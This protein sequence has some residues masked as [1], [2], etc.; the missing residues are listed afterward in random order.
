MQ[1]T[2][3]QINEIINSEELSSLDSFLVKIEWFWWDSYTT[4][5]MSMKESISVLNHYVELLKSYLPKKQELFEQIINYDIR[6]SILNA[7][8][9][10][11]NYIPKIKNWTDYKN[12]F[13]QDVQILQWIFERYM[14]EEKNDWY[15]NY[16]KKQE[17]ITYLIRRY[18]SLQG[19]LDNFEQ[20]YNEVSGSISEINNS[21]SDSKNK[22]EEINTIKDKINDTKSEIDSVRSKI[23]E[24]R[25]NAIRSESDITSMKETINDF[26]NEIE[27]NREKMSQSIKNV[28]D[29]S[30]KFKENIEENLKKNE[31]NT[32]NIINKNE[33][34]Q[35]K[36]FDLMWKATWSKLYA[37]FN[38]RSN[39]LYNQKKFWWKILI[40]WVMLATWLSVWIIY[41]LWDFFSTWDILDIKNYFWL[42]IR[43]LM[44]FPLFYAIYF[45]ANQFNTNNKLEEE[46]EF[47]SSLSVTL[48]FFK[49][50]L[51]DTKEE[52][53]EFIIE[54]IWK[55]FS[56]PT[57]SVFWSKIT[58]KNVYEIIKKEVKDYSEI[59]WNINK[60]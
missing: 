42:W 40:I 28:N 3:E 30:D 57:E 18:K 50:L 37:S 53:K 32:Q 33:E 4:R 7:L 41:S 26:F 10:L 9:N 21:N 23:E 51:E 52:D 43:F 38:E 44:L 46:Y 35:K 2:T 56:S 20:Q 13:I 60:K 16:K 36:I 59:L 39:S 55:I 58:K 31:E 5:E 6:S 19:I 14:L 29:M 45:A 15:P 48:P 22:L 1:N 25:D 12:N 17:E 34:L 49:D 54:S 11:K 24:L 8:N 27:E 47:K